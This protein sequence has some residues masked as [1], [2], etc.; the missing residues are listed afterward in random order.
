MVHFLQK[1][2]PQLVLG[3][4]TV[5]R[6]WNRGLGVQLKDM[7]SRGQNWKISEHNQDDESMGKTFTALTTAGG[8]GG[9]NMPGSDFSCNIEVTVVL[10]KQGCQASKCQYWLRV[11][12]HL[13]VNA[14]QLQIQQLLKVMNPV[15]C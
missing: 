13:L 14:L 4:G 11:A 8:S 7:A 2:F 12:T 10:E 15:R 5:A 3:H 9:K 1:K 6:R